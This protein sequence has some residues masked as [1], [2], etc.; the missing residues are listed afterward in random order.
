MRK[1][2][3]AAL[4]LLIAL[5]TILTVIVEEARSRQQRTA[6]G[7]VGETLTGQ[8][9]LGD[10]TTDAPGVRRR[11]TVADLPLPYATRSVDNGP[12][13]V[14]RPPN[15][16][17]QVPAGFK[18]E[19]FL[20]GLENPRLIRTA[21]NGDIFLAES[22]PG[23][24]RVLRARNGAGRPDVNEV[25]VSGLDR[26]FGIAFYPLG[27]DPQFVYVANT[28]AVMRFPYRNG[29]LKT[30]GKGEVIVS[31]LPGGG[32][33]RGGGHWTR[34]LAFSL[35]GKKMFVSVG[36]RSNVYQNPNE[37][38]ERRAAILE[39]NPDGTG[40]RLYATGVRNAVG[41]AIHPESGQLWASVN[42]RD[43]LGDDLVPDYITRVKEGGFYGWPW[44]YLG[45]NQDPR[46]PLAHPELR[47]KVLVPDVLLQSHSASL[48]MVFYSG[49][50]FPAEY[51]NSAFAAQ[52]GS[53]NRARRTGYKVIRV[54]VRKGI[55][56][57]EYEDFMTGFVTPQGDVWGR[58][59]GVAVGRDGS[60][61]VTDDGAN[62]IW[63]ISYQRRT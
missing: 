48:E 30:R 7:Q 40:F 44:F 26:P 52:H 9:A 19:E 43:G 14:K 60:L 46:H 27:P 32:Q 50:E 57:G 17:P 36:S 4:V 54:P 25:F 34:D 33:L 24:I 55:P 10:W 49:Q 29:D 45:P 12:Q 13:L 62:T 35:D 1:R 58:P 39:Y 37:N 5:G 20:T 53:W 18:V 41:I 59:V 28:G 2:F 63:R 23:R 21:P 51:L 61:F 56:T 16:W 22:R 8:G 31:D 38:E 42:E 6:I 15:A 47:D 3:I 11:I